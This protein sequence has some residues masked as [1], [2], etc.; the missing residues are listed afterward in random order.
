MADNVRVYNAF[1]VATL[2]HELHKHW[3]DRV[4]KTKDMKGLPEVYIV[5]TCG[6]WIAAPLT[7]EEGDAVYAFTVHCAQALTDI[8]D[9]FRA[10]AS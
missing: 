1:L 7:V 8:P 5:C 10:S 3:I 2:A 4:E 6:T 9:I